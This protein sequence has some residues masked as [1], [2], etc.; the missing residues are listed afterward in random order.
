MSDSAALR[1]L[2]TT[3]IAQLPDAAEHT[4]W[5][6]QQLW[7]RAAVGILGGSPKSC[8]SWLALDLA[9]SVASATPAVGRFPVDDSGAVVLFMAEDSAALVKQRV[10]GLCAQRALQLHTLPLHLITEPV[11][12]IDRIRDQQRLQHTLCALRPRMLVLDPF[13]RI[14]RI[15][16]NDA[17]QV[18]AVLG[19]LRQLQRSLDLAV[20]VVHHARKNGSA[21]QPGQNLRGSSDLHAWGD[22]NLFLKRKADALTLSI[23]HRAAPAIDPLSLRLSAD[24]THAHLT[25]VDDGRKTEHDELELQHAILDALAGA[26]MTRQ[27]LRAT[28]RVRN[29]RLGH[30]LD[31]LSNA[32][33]IIRAGDRWTVPVPAP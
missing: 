24:G 28:L 21:A 19:F 20:L 12:R 30:A 3:P 7:A 9:V 23:E 17:G 8:K 14:Q 25:L 32:G 22:S 10:A 18:A 29:Q 15:D 6:V 1:P 5:L 33:A 2:A 31:Q 16:E 26:P 11:L 27:L 13:V 4:H